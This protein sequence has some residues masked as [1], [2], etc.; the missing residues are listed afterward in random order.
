MKKIMNKKLLCLLLGV[1]MLMSITL[2]SCSEKTKD[3]QASDIQEEASKDAV[4]L[5]MY[6]MSEKPVHPDTAAAIENEVNKI[7]KAKFTTQMKLYFYTED[8]YYQ[9]LEDSF[10]ARD[11]AKANGTLSSDAASTEEDTSSEGGSAVE[12]K[13]PTIAGY[14]VDIFYFG[15]MERYQ[16]YASDGRLSNLSFE[17]SETGGSNSIRKYVSPH[18]L[19]A[20]QAMGGKQGQLNALPTNKTIGEYTYLL[21]NKEALKEAKRQVENVALD[22]SLYTSLTCDDTQDFLNYVHTYLNTSYAP[23]YTNL[24][25]EALLINNL[26]FWGVDDSGSLSDAFSV[27]GNYMDGS[28]TFQ[29]AGAY[30]AQMGNLFENE[31][32]VSDLTTL[33]QY[34]VNGYYQPEG[35]TRAFAVG[36]V[37]GGAELEAVYGDDYEMIVLEKPTLDAEAV[38]SDLFGVAYCTTDV[39][40]SMEILTYLN[41]NESFRNLLLYGVEGTHYQLNHVNSKGEAVEEDSEGERYPVVKRLLVDSEYEY[42][43]SVHRTGNELLAYPE[44][45][46]APTVNEYGVKQNRDAR[47]DLYCGF[48]VNYNQFGTN[49][50]ELRTVKNLSAGLLQGYLACNTAEEFNAYL[51]AARQTVATSEAVKNQLNSEAKDSL[52][53]CYTAWKTAM[54]IK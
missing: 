19:T 20:L 52:S 10:A 18:F 45:G 3:E 5:S 44:E 1:L 6:L 53:A 7:T 9:K 47:I 41:T 40:R 13:Y 51:T 31:Q 25:E 2:T 12:I 21:L 35:D 4:T 23:L 49:V 15:G 54:K 33:N 39:A 38:Y 27:L 14:Q 29:D 32:F 30:S 8:E 17:L 24:T 22:K 11:A 50:E 43:M 42:K 16:K 46:T 37:K 28:A 36:Y 48:T 34:K 26:K